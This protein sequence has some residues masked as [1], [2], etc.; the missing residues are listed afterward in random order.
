MNGYVFAVVVGTDFHIKTWILLSALLSHHSRFFK[1]AIERSFR[2]AKESRVTLS[3]ESPVVF[4]HFVQWVYIGDYHHLKKAEEGLA[5]CDVPMRSAE[6][7]VL[8]DRLCCIGL[9]DHAMRHLIQMH[10]RHVGDPTSLCFMRLDIVAYAFANTAP[11]SKLRI[12]CVDSLVWHTKQN[13]HN[14]EMRMA[15]MDTPEWDIL[16]G[17]CDDFFRAFFHIRATCTRALSSSSHGRKMR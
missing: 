5:Q 12:F 6:V 9:K 4:E 15:D 1:A 13:D 3:E 8:V 2:E 14:R 16:Y 7:W 17:N 10:E 11:N